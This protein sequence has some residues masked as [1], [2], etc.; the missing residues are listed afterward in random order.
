LQPQEA[1]AAPIMILNPANEEP[2][3]QETGRRTGRIDLIDQARGAALL[4]MA[5]YHFAWDLEFFGYVAQGTV[6]GGGW[7]L[8]ARAIA[9]SFLF[10]VGVSLVLAH[11]G[12][13]RWHAFSQRM[14]RVV[15]AALLIT[16]ATYIVF[17]DAF[18][19]FGILHHI[20]LASLLGLGFLRLPFLVLVIAILF[21]LAAPHFLRNDLFGHPVLWWI[22]L[23]PANPHSND[24]VPLF[25]WFAAVLT[26]ILAAR[27]ARQRGLLERMA[28]LSLPD[29]AGV[30]RLAGQHSLAFYLLHQPVLIGSLWLFA[31][32]LPPAAET[33]QV[34]FLEACRSRCIAERDSDFCVRYCACVLDGV[35]RAGRLDALFTGRPSQEPPSWLQEMA[36]Q[37]SEEVGREREP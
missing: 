2:A 22:G 19:F 4:A 34:Q 24:Y 6:A 32:V 30:L 15:A 33:R 5:V 28:S 35:E 20:A 9:F 17:P 14:L 13:I 23:S 31:L 1:A 26:G 3:M 12:G 37:C 16:A 29:G 25:P 8:F 7:R 27:L 11:D 21:S 10:L 36:F 18:I